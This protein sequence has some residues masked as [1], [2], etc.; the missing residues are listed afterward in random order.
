MSELQPGQVWERYRGRHKGAQF[1]VVRET[2]PDW[3][4][5]R[6]ISARHREKREIYWPDLQGAYRLLA[7]DTE[8]DVDKEAQ[9]VERLREGLER[10]ARMGTKRIPV[11]RRK[12]YPEQSSR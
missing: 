1:E 4:L 11:L 12:G 9:E 2:V 6:F 5:V 3:W 7:K 10:I 8:D